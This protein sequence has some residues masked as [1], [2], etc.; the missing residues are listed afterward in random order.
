MPVLCSYTHFP[1]ALIYATH[2]VLRMTCRLP[3]LNGLHVWVVSCD[4][5]HVSSGRGCGLV[6]SGPRIRQSCNHPGRWIQAVG[7]NTRV[8]FCEI[9]YAGSID[10]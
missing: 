7:T 5:A 6:S 8:V 3:S 9:G 2:H 4:A 10:H 1:H